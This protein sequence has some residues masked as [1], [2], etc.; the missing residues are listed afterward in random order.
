MFQC[1]PE[2]SVDSHCFPS[3]VHGVSRE[4]II[5]I[6]SSESRVNDIKKSSLWQLV[7]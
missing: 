2:V 5:E 7:I 3:T 6:T 1:K 4:T